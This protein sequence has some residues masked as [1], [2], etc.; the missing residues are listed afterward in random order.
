MN[1]TFRFQRRLVV[2]FTLAA[3]FALL[4]L[5]A[6][7]RGSAPTWAKSAAAAVTLIVGGTGALIAA[8]RGTTRRRFMSAMLLVIVAELVAL[9]VF[10]NA[11][12]YLGGCG[13]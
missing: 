2:A 10:F 8:A 4:M 11:A 12:C 9:N 13:H 6:S 5:A 7:L 1:P 3:L